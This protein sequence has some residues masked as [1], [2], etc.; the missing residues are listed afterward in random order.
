VWLPA[1]VTLLVHARILGYF[2][3]AH[4]FHHLF[5]VANFGAES[6]V[7]PFAG[8]V[9]IAHKLLFYLLF[10]LVGMNP[11]PYFAFALLLH[12]INVQLLASLIRRLTGRPLLAVFGATLWGA[13]PLLHEALW[14]CTAH[15][16]VMVTTA[17]LWIL[18]DLARLDRDAAVP[19]RGMLARWCLL[20]VVASTSDGFGAAIALTFAGV[21]QLLLPESPRRSRIALSFLGLSAL[22]VVLFVAVR[23]LYTQ[24]SGETVPVYVLL[25]GPG[26]GSSLRVLELLVGLMSSSVAGL[27]A[28]P[29]LAVD[30]LSMHS[31]V[32]RGPLS[33]LELGQIL[34]LSQAIA[35]LFLALVLWSHRGASARD[36]RWLLGL[37]GLMVVCFASLVLGRFEAMAGELAGL[38]TVLRPQHHYLTS[39]LV[40]VMLC[41][42]LARFSLPSWM[43]MRPALVGLGCAAALLV[44][45]SIQVTSTLGSPRRG[46]PPTNA[47]PTYERLVGLIEDTA[48][49]QPEGS[50]VITP[51]RRLNIMHPP[52]TGGLARERQLFPDLAAIFVITYPGESLD[53]RRVRF[54]EPEPA[55][56]KMFVDRRP[57]SRTARL[58]INPKQA[59][60]EGAWMPPP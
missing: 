4:D 33:G 11:V 56:M 14:W 25:L 45:L 12:I 41:A 17:V 34:V 36:R 50:Q 31:G 15:G 7:E 46:K 52:P 44:L 43:A 18:C 58:L 2:F 22:I 35:A 42:V 49:S 10:P 47:R 26:P 21:A 53:G 59:M 13:A 54:I 5:Q 28:G 30:P 8:Q 55:L 51:N 24:I 23:W 60:A 19:S 57:R 48:H 37:F 3:M 27:L 40:A 1:I 20:L 16:Q 38:V 9:V 39:S 6:L 29:L 32:I